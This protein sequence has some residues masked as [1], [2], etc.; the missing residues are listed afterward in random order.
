MLETIRQTARVAG[1]AGW[2]WMHGRVRD[3]PFSL[4]MTG[5]G[6][7]DPYACYRRLRAQGPLSRSTSGVW[8]VTGH[9]LCGRV[10]RDRRFGVRNGPYVRDDSEPLAYRPGAEADFSLLSL[11]PPDHGR[12]RRL[13]APAF[14]PKM[15]ARYRPGIERITRE[16]LDRAAA[17]GRFDLMAKVAAPLPIAVISELLGIPDEHAGP[18]RE[19]GAVVAG[20]LDGVPS[21]RTARALGPATRALEE[22]FADLLRQRAARPGQDVLSRLAA[23]LGAARVSPREVLSL[24]RVLLIAGFE[25]TVNL[26]G[27]G[28]LALLDHPD[29]WAMLRANPDMAGQVV[30]EVLRYDPPVQATLRYAQEDLYL[31]GRRIAAWDPLYVLIGATGRDPSVFTGPDR[32]DIT[33]TRGADHLAFGSGP[34]YCLG[35]PLARLEGEIFFRTVATRLPGLVRAGE[36]EHRS[37]MTVRGLARLPVRPG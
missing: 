30:E 3:D 6:R 17:R 20:S 2:T 29:Q 35:A 21:L 27:N 34:H 22:L 15:M 32:F 31:A 1:H 25:T 5:A 16:L 19:Y 8:A 28:M 11:D 10:L 23:D 9:R 7:R 12:V 4:L 18:F 36:P 26:I 14:S 13:A 37:T 24:C 33:R